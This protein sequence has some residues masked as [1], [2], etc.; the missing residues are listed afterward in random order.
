MSLGKIK[1]LRGMEVELVV[2]VGIKGNPPYLNVKDDLM[3]ITLQKRNKGQGQLDPL[4][5]DLDQKR[6]MLQRTQG[7]TS[8]KLSSAVTVLIQGH[9]WVESASLMV[10][11]DGQLFEYVEK[12]QQHGQSTTHNK[13]ENG[14]RGIE[15]SVYN[16]FH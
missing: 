14:S 4:S 8:H 5:A 2:E 13:P 6:L 11:K 10:S 16:L 12:Q 3:H 1:E 15:F 7:S 9:S